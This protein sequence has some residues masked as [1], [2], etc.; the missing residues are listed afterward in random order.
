MLDIWPSCKLLGWEID[1]VVIVTSFNILFA[2]ENI[3]LFD[4]E[5]RDN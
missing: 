2:S 5:I 1:G 4:P 3:T